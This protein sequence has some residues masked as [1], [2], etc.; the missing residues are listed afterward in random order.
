MDEG[1]EPPPEQGTRRA[2]IAAGTR[3]SPLQESYGAAAAHSLACDWCR[4]IDRTRCDAGEQLW[5][6]YQEISEAAYRRLADDR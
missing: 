2:A 5:R 4:D 1:R 3:L 6:A